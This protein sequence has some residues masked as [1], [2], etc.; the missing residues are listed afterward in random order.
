[1]PK[2]GIVFFVHFAINVYEQL[3]EPRKNSEHHVATLFSAIDSPVSQ[4]KRAWHAM[5]NIFSRRFFSRLH[6]LIASVKENCVIGDVKK[7]S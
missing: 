3:Q 6:Y 7:N 4:N 1:M 2:L 5:K